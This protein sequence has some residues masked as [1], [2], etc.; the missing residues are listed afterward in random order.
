MSMDKYN[1]FY[2]E[3]DDDSWSYCLK[4]LESPWGTD[5]EWSRERFGSGK[6]AKLALLKRFPDVLR[7]V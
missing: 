6:E 1:I 4:R 3:N 2:K 5:E 7:K